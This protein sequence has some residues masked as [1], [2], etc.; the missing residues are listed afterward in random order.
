MTRRRWLAPRRQPLRLSTP[1]GTC[2]DCHGSREH[3]GMPPLALGGGD[4]CRL[5][6]GQA[7]DWVSHEQNWVAASRSCA[8]IFSGERGGSVRHGSH[9]VRRFECDLHR[10]G[11]PIDRAQPTEHP[12]SI[13]P[14]GA[15][16]RSQR[17]PGRSRGRLPRARS[18]LLA[19]FERNRSRPVARRTPRRGDAAGAS[20][21]VFGSFRRSKIRGAADEARRCKPASLPLGARGIAGQG[22]LPP[23]Q[24]SR[25]VAAPYPDLRESWI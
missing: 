24:R 14:A 15:G 12:R 9:T 18:R 25:Q 5:G 2:G 11:S 22:Q 1:L 7:T 6:F 8:W 23:R 19:A 10:A 20:N 3:E 17:R 4:L 13:G 16:V 21:P